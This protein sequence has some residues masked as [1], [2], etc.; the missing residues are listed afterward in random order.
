MFFDQ[1]R[2][3]ETKKKKCGKFPNIWEVSNTLLNNIWV[4]KET[5]KEIR[6]YFELNDKTQHIK[7]L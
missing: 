6:K 5:T 1:H 4:R 3:K 7:I 2:I